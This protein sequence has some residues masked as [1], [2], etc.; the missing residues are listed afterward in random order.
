MRSSQMNDPVVVTDRM[1][2]GYALWFT[3]AFLIG[4]LERVCVE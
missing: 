3:M 2:L 4:H 1:R